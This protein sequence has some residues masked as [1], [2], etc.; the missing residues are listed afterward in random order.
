[1]PLA[2]RPPNRRVERVGAERHTGSPE[3]LPERRCTGL[4]WKESAKGV[5]MKRLLTGALA[6]GG[7]GL[8]A[9]AHAEAGQSQ[10][11]HTNTA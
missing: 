3:R 5:A 10:M 8:A 4:P 7:L 9:V 2:P 1:M 6:S 11:Y